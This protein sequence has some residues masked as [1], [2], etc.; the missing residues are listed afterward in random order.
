MGAVIVFQ[1]DWI[2]APVVIVVYINNKFKAPVSHKYYKVQ[3]Q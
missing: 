3:Y 1:F 2:G